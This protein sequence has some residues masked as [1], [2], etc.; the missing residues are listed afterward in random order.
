MSVSMDRRR[1][2]RV[3]LALG[4][5]FAVHQKVA[6]GSSAACGGMAFERLDATAI[7]LLGREY[8]SQRPDLTAVDHVARLLTDAE[9]EAQALAQL[10]ARVVADFTAARMVNLG[11]WFVSETEGCVFAALSRCASEQG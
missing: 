4:A 2:L 7:Q 10:R 9:N 8:L 6:F 1:L 5:S 11:G 3:V